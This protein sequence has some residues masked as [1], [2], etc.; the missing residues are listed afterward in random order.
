MPHPSLDLCNLRNLPRK[1]RKLARG[2][3][4]NDADSLERLDEI[5]IWVQSP[6]SSE[7]SALFLP[8]FYTVLK[9]AP[10]D[11]DFTTTEGMN[12]FTDIA[13]RAIPVLKSLAC[14]IQS[15]STPYEAL[16][17]LWPVM[18]QHITLQHRFIVVLVGHS[19]VL[20]AALF[21]THLSII[22]HIASRGVEFSAL[23]VHRT[24]GI[25]VVVA[26]IW[27]YFVNEPTFR[28]R[29]GVA[30]DMERAIGIFH[31]QSTRHD[32]IAA[33]VE[34]VGGSLSELTPVILDQL[35]IITSGLRSSPD[36]EFPIR[37]FEFLVRLMS[38][39][40]ATTGT[41]LV[42]EGVVA[43]VVALAIALQRKPA[44]A[45]ANI[46]KLVSSAVENCYVVID[47]YL[48]EP[49]GRPWV[50]EA[51]KSGLLW[52]LAMTMLPDE[53]DDDESMHIQEDLIVKICRHFA[54][55]SVIRCVA[56][57]LA[58]LEQAGWTEKLRDSALWQ[59]WLSM[60]H[61]AIARK[62]EFD[63]APAP[64]QF[65]DNVSCDVISQRK[66]LRRCTGCEIRCYC[67]VAC[68]KEDWVAKFNHK[69]FCAH[70]EPRGSDGVPSKDK[71]FVLYTL[72]ADYLRYKST[73]L[74]KRVIYMAK[75]SSTDCYTEWD[76]TGNK[77]GEKV[78]IK[79]LLELQ[80]QAP[81]QSRNMQCADLLHRMCR[82]RG[83]MDVDV[84]LVP[85]GY[86]AQYW[87]F[88]MRSSSARLYEWTEKAAYETRD[89]EVTS[90]ECARWFEM[91]EDGG[92]PDLVEI[93]SY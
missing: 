23:I 47:A 34:G 70:L 80:E 78:S 87:F 69:S 55:Y 44:V 10:T 4:L 17:D 92:G 68:Q 90:E 6:N 60:A 18:W 22:R 2:A 83:T 21:S 14:I 24:P 72:H 42:A 48:R 38:I 63:N 77:D 33:I 65:C 52:S 13:S 86:Q 71:A 20:E 58:K 39:S 76:Y 53:P 66:D 50:I 61:D 5:C 8:V 45:D 54:Y 64:M 43:R 32:G 16:V 30:S 46:N 62:L 56:K 11:V 28:A 1:L 59:A 35:D 73:V 67:S 79:S 82:S 37:T 9:A 84:A 75:T 25:R 12:A 19:P 15:G 91:I 85:W 3:C 93:H 7:V 26:R 81:S 27:K 49:P 51:V 29:L 89:G 88:P 57:S 41:L 40:A 36:D 31:L 74:G